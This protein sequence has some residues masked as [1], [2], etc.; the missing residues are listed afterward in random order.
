M[1]WISR[2]INTNW[3]KLLIVEQYVA[4]YPHYYFFVEILSQNL[5][6]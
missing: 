4:I 2:D 3:Y 6:N 5:S 1:H